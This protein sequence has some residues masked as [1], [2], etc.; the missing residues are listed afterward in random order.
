MD[1][2]T[3]GSAFTST[4][5]MAALLMSSCSPQAATQN[6]PKAEAVSSK[7]AIEVETIADNLRAPWRVTVLPDGG[8]LVTERAGYLLRITQDGARTKI[9]GLPDDIYVEGQ[10]GL[11]DII[12]SPDFTDTGTVFL[13]YAKGTKKANHTAIYKARLV[14]DDLVGGQVIFQATPTKDTNAHFGAR[15]VSYLTALWS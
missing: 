13:S 4:L 14:G 9:T 12:L 15:M 7:A 11:F 8:Y 3:T 2:R 10:G 1:I 6:A 5:F